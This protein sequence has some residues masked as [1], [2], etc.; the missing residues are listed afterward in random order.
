MVKTLY[1]NRT[2]QQSCGGSL[3]LHFY[4]AVNHLKLLGIE[5]KTRGGVC[6]VKILLLQL[7][8]AAAH[9]CS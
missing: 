9:C 2:M 1:L 3:F 6:A 7:F 4:S 5:D 8:G